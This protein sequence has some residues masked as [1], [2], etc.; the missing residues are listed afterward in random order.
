MD[1]QRDSINSTGRTS[2][3]SILPFTY[4]EGSLSQRAAG[5]PTLSY[6]LALPADAVAGVLVLHGYGEHGGRYRRV[7]ERWAKAKVA[8]AVVDFR[9]HGWSAGDRGHCE[10]FADYLEDAADMLATFRE[11]LVEVAGANVPLFVMGHSFGGLVA[12]H[13]ALTMP[14]AFRGLVLSS[15][16]FGLHLEVASAK[17]AAGEIASRIFPR[18]S[19]PSGISGK[20]VTRDETIARQYDNDPL[21]NKVANARWFTEAQLAQ[22]DLLARAAQLKL[23]VLVVQAG[24]DRVASAAASRAVFDRIGSADKKFDERTGLYHEVLNE[25]GAGEQIADEM[26]EWVVEHAK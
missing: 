11:R 3:I 19:L 4:E 10:S 18:L 16:F 8:S 12:A 20:D 26:A 21:V 24:A 22:R 6:Q 14:G 5:A 2:R 1:S 9:G 13:F 25:P 7:I 15:P 17:R 23:P